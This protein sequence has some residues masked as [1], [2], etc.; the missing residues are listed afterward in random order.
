MVIDYQSLMT[1]QFLSTENQYNLYASLSSSQPQAAMHLAIF[2][3][4]EAYP[5]PIL[6][7]L[8]FRAQI[9]GGQDMK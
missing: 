8:P 1:M 6:H 5:Y 7:T 2:L 3:E 4:A 9:S